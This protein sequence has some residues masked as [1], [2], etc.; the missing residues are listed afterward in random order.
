MT[1]GRSAKRKPDGADAYPAYM[2]GE[3][4]KTISQFS[5]NFALQAGGKL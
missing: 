4:I 1:A 2:P 3:K 5:K